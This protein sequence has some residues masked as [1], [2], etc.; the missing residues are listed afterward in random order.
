VNT[1]M[2][3]VSVGLGLLLRLGVPVLLLVGMVWLMR[4]LDARWQA[5]AGQPSAAIR[6]PALKCWEVHQCSLERRATCV[7][8]HHPEVP[9]WQQFRDRDGN[10]RAGCL[11]CELFASLPAGQPARKIHYVQD[12]PAS[13]PGRR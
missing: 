6:P 9:C 2:G 7:V 13:E 4:R 10:L 12:V 5:E 1:L 3:W 11:T 8:P